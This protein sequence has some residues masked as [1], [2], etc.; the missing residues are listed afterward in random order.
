M[1][2]SDVRDKYNAGPNVA[3]QLADSRGGKE[4]TEAIDV[5]IV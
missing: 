3:Q 1:A 5:N 2:A 4:Y